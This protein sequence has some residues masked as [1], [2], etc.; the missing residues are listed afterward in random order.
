MT[1]V[2]TSLLAFATLAV[3]VAGVAIIAWRAT[4]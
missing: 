2:L 1:D 4:R 3:I